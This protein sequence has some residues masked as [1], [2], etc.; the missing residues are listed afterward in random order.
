MPRFVE[1]ERE[2]AGS[3][4]TPMFTLQARGLLS[5]NYAAYRALGQ[6]ELVTL[7]YDEDAQIVGVRLVG[8]GHPNAHRVRPQGGS[9]IVG[10]QKFASHYGIK[11]LVAQRFVAHDYGGGVW[12]FALTEGRAVSNRRGASDLASAYTAR[13]RSTTDGFEVP[14]LMRLRDAGP[15]GPAWTNHSPGK[16]PASVRIGALI[17]CEPLGTTPSTPELGQCF[18]HFMAS[19]NIMG[20][21]KSLTQIRGGST[22]TRWPGNGRIM[23][24]AGLANPLGSRDNPANVSAWARLILP[25]VAMSSYG[26]DPRFAQLILNV[27]PR[28]ADGGP[29]EP[30][31]IRVWHRRFTEAFEI[32]ES[33]NT[34]LEKT[35]G[36]STSDDPAAQFGIELKTQRITDLV[37]L[38]GL[39]PLEGSQTVPWY[40][41]WNIADR[42]GKPPAETAVDLLRNMCDY[43][44]RVDDYEELLDSLTQ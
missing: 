29:P 35:L 18:L 25:E 21:V 22:W 2:S 36:L 14:A 3:T 4:E 38:S 42:S 6:P 8:E 15:P 24:E 17:A 43:T 5:L 26:R 12:G 37:S 23:L 33:L 9:Y 13:W 7:L 41:G 27:E 40:M 30:E 31:D 1:F 10:A 34:F 44:L 28:A 20:I 19:S 39:T 32:A 16:E 11:P